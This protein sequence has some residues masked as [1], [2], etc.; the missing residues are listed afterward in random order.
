MS[1]SKFLWLQYLDVPPDGVAT[2]RPV[3][4]INNRSARAA[5]RGEIWARVSGVV[6]GLVGGARLC[7]VIGCGFWMAGARSNGVTP[8][9]VRGLVLNQVVLTHAGVLVMW[10][11]TKLFKSDW[12][13]E[14]TC[15]GLILVHPLC[16]QTK[17]WGTGAT[18]PISLNLWQIILSPSRTLRT[19][20]SFLKSTLGTVFAIV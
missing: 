20:V 7:S 11:D 19:L 16:P 8:P 17:A 1:A 5:V 12:R 15:V 4:K 3:P 2:C 14:Q 9:C 10:L 6:V 18:S 13:S